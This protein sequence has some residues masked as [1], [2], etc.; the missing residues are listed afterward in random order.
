MIVVEPVVSEELEI[1]A[2]KV[3]LWA[4]LEHSGTGHVIVLACCGRSGVYRDDL[5]L[6]AVDLVRS[7][8][9]ATPMAW[10]SSPGWSGWMQLR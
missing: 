2:G 10:F 9:G 5:D 8:V 6:L 1:P 7:F 3:R 4:R